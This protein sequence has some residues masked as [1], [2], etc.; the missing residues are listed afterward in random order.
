MNLTTAIAINATISA[1]GAA[2]AIV[3]NHKLKKIHDP[4]AASATRARLME[5]HCETMKSFQ[6]EV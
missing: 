5:K 6:K 3:C 1:A 2:F 4:A